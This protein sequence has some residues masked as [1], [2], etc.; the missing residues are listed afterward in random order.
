MHNDEPIHRICARAAAVINAKIHWPGNGASAVSGWL[1]T[2]RITHSIVFPHKCHRISISR[3]RNDANSQQRHS[4]TSCPAAKL[5][6]VNTPF[7]IPPSAAFNAP[8]MAVV[9]LDTKG[10]SVAATSAL[11][12]APALYTEDARI[13]ALCA[14]APHVTVR[15]RCKGGAAYHLPVDDDELA[16][17]TTLELVELVLLGIGVPQ[18][19]L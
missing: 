5:P 11:T 9:G 2:I 19:T 3:V 6:I 4:R 1:I 12:L 14:P 8:P 7:C 18:V 15:V 13:G 16:P 17:E 10:Q